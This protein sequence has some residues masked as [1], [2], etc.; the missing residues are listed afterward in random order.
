MVLNKVSKK[1]AEIASSAEYPCKDS[2]NFLITQKNLNT[3]IQVLGSEGRI[4]AAE[5]S[6]KRVGR[7]TKS[8]ALLFIP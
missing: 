1:E 6:K 3:R 7:V 8:Q 2:V 5:W 4:P